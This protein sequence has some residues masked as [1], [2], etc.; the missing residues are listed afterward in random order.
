MNGHSDEL[1]E[2]VREILKWVRIQAQPDARS[3]IEKALP[4]AAHRRLYQAL[5]GK[6]TQGQLASLMKTSQ[7]TVSRLIGSWVRAGIA[8]E[9]SPGR[10][11]KT[12]DLVE[13]GIDLDSKTGR[14]K[15]AN[16]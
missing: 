4:E 3:A 7:P 16:R 14:I 2:A 10:Y 12:F 13:L 6:Q 8:E 15:N 11:T 9:T 5:D 1:L